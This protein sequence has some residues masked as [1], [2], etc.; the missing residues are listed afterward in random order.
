MGMF[1]IEP[2]RES[3]ALRQ[4]VVQI[5]PAQLFLEIQQLGILANQ[6]E[7]QSGHSGKIFQV[8]RRQNLTEASVVSATRQYPSSS[9]SL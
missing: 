2:Y 7:F 5:I 6:Q 4:M 3:Q 1:Y 8:L 9:R